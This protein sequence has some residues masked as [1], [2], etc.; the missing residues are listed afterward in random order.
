LLQKF[1]CEEN[2]FFYFVT[3]TPF[4][5]G[6]KKMFLKEHPSIIPTIA[7]KIGCKAEI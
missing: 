2:A 6:K 3:I 4:C 5:I 7:L 1:F